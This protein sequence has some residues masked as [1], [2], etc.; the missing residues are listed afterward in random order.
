MKTKKPKKSEMEK[1]KG[2]LHYWQMYGRIYRRWVQGAN[3]KVKEIAA[4]MRAL[5]QAGK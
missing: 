5:Q 3:D 2:A 4:K 1:L